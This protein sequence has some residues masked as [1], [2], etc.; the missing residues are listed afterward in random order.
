MHPKLSHLQTIQR[1]FAPFYT[2]FFIKY[3]YSQP[4]AHNR[5]EQVCTPDEVFLDYALFSTP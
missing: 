4:Y 5:D 3:N 1:N 2:R